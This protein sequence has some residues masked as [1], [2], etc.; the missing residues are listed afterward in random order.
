MICGS[1]SFSV[2][3]LRADG[4]V[5]WRA[6]LSDSVNGLAVCGMRIVAGCD[7]GRA[8]I[9]DRSGKVLG[10]AALPAPATHVTRLDDSMAVVAAGNFVLAIPVP[11]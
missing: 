8:Y 3:A 11:H 9:L 6:Q 4:S 1:E 7:D 10:A 2:Y 5:A